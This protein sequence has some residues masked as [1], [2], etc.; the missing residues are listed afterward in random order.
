MSEELA[1]A[2]ST[3]GDLDLGRL[4]LWST[5][6]PPSLRHLA[7]TRAYG[8]GGSFYVD[9]ASMAQTFP[10][11]TEEGVRAFGRQSGYVAEFIARDPE[12]T[13]IP[14]GYDLVAVTG[15]HLFSAPDGVTRW[16]DEMFV[17]AWSAQIDQEVGTS[18][19]LLLVERL[20]LSGFAETAAGLRILQAGEVGP[21]SSTMIYFRL[22][23]LLGA[24]WLITL[25]N[26]ER[27]GVVEQLAHTLERH[28][29]QV[30]LSH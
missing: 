12:G 16:I 27:L 19:R 14:L 5:D 24:V 15:V 26:C 13:T 8:R 23:R 9:N 18:G 1:R 11:W 28:I 20:H 6:L 7:L 30:V 17:G 2:T 3:V 25:G 22:G 21:V 29:M 10:G 4:V